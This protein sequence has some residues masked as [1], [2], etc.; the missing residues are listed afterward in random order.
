M[1]IR[2]PGPNYYTFSPSARY[3]IYVDKNGDGKPETTYHFRFKNQ[4]SQFFL[5]NTQQS[6]TVTKVVKG[7]STVVGSGLLTPP[8]NIGPKSTPDYHSLAA[9]GVP[10]VRR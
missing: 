3:D 10:T 5:G 7:K 1:R 2:P 9:A 8:D 4:P 6:N